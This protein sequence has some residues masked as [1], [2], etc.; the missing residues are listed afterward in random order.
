MK[1]VNRVM[2][3]QAFTVRLQMSKRSRDGFKYKSLPTKD[4]GG[5]LSG[6]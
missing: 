3:A 6:L 4:G 5:R 2:Y 1:V